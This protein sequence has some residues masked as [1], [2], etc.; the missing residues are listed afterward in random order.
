VNWR[1]MWQL[2]I[3]KNLINSYLNYSKYLRG[4]IFEIFEF[5]TDAGV[6]KSSWWVNNS[7]TVEDGTFSLWVPY[8]STV[9]M[10]NE[11]KNVSIATLFQV[12]IY[13]FLV[14]LFLRLIGETRKWTVRAEWKDWPDHGLSELRQTAAQLTYLPHPMG[15]LCSLDI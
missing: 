10:E 5:W 6:V 13:F 11:N 15:V 7:Y 1:T 2:D 4:L 14:R 8:A 12:F 9:Y 3:K